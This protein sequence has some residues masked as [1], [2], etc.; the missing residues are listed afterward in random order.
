MLTAKPKEPGIYDNRELLLRE[1]WKIENGTLKISHS[2]SKNQ[3]DV[4]IDWEITPTGQK[5]FPAP[6][7]GHYPDY[8]ER[9]HT[10]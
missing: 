6:A 10:R 8:Q 5:S 1:H 2:T 4:G 9:S 3:I 7:W